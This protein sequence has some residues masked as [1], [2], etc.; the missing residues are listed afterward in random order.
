MVE[1]VLERLLYRLAISPAGR[2]HFVLKG[3]LLLAQFGARRTTRDID[4]LGR[5]FTGDDTEITRRVRA[6]AA[7]EA[8]D[9]V[10]FDSASLRTAPTREDGRY[11]GL[12]LIIPASITRAQLKLQLDISLGDPITPAPQPWLRRQGPA[13]ATQPASRTQP[14]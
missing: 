11:H 12:R 7:T 14:P 8:D 2:E 4:I 9:G 13:A 5:A 10:A 1:Y 3:G 6:N